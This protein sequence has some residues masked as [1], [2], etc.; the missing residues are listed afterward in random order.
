MSRINWLSEGDFNTTFFHR[1]CQVR[2]SY[3]D[4]RSLLFAAGDMVTD[5]I[6]MSEL[7][8]GHFKSI[9]GPQNYSPPLLYSS[10]NWFTELVGFE[11][12]LQQCQQ[13]LSVPSAEEIKNF[14]SG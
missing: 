13:M 5:P 11:C 14:S 4:I 2:A 8:V 7:A 3:N 10:Y 1:M 12:S 6:E 9:L